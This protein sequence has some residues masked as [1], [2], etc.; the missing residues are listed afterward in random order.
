MSISTNI[1]TIGTTTCLDY[2]TII[3][4]YNGSVIENPD[5]SVSVFLPTDSGF[6]PLILGKTCCEFI[7]PTYTFDIETQTCKWTEKVSGCSLDNIIKLVINP[8]GNDGTLFYVVDN[9]N[10]FLNIDFNYLFKIKCETL[11]DIINTN[12]GC[13]TPIEL[14]ETFD[15]SLTIDII[16]SASTLETVVEIPLFQPIGTGNLYNYLSGIT[17]SGF[18]VC[19]DST[20]GCI[21]LTLNLTGLT[22]PNTSSCDYVMTNI[23][24]GLFNE[25]GLSGLSSANDIFISSITQNVL[26]S[27][28]L[29][30][31]TAITDTTIINSIKNQLIKL[32]IKINHACSDFCV[33]LD[34]IILDKV[35]THVD[36]TDIFL[37]QSPGF[38][39]NRVI[40]NKKSWTSNSTPINRSFDITNNL[41]GNTIRQTNYDINDERLVINTKEID[42]DINLASAIETDV[43]YY[44]L[45]NPC[46]LTGITTCDPCIITGTSLNHSNCCGDNSIDFT[47]LMTQ[48]LS[49]VTT[50]EDFEYFLT[51]ELIDAKNRQTISGYPTL[52]ALYDRYINSGLY[53]SAISSKFDYLTMD[54]FASLIGNYW[55]DIVEQVVPAT[56]IWGSVKIY[57]NT[58]FDQQKFKYKA[59]SSLFCGNPF[60]GQTLPSPINGTSGTC[61]SVNVITTPINQQ[62]GNNINIKNSITTVCDTLCLAQMNSGSEFLGTISIVGPSTINC[63][64]TSVINECSLGATVNAIYPNASV[65]LVGATLP[66]TYLWSNSGTG[67]TTTFSVSG[68]YNVQ[69]TDAACCSINIEFNI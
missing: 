45:D 41:G 58:I 6:S 34:E 63:D 52:R 61:T 36:R 15:V 24:E 8:K 17:N 66:V 57:S 62:V 3:I 39:L 44:I 23:I 64:N 10:C 2:N 13:S 19:G 56:T 46:L 1:N 7:K 29:N 47:S 69:I 49:G 37:T 31:T 60:S 32:S 38:E 42:L 48:P 12:K 27:N 30:F 59:Y 50:I 35:C 55:V 11:S 54:Q 9:D 43:W 25:S 51:S 33:L 14:F 26:A 67:A 4:D 16:T 18:Y 21:P 53:C 5:G 68:K 40:D 20:D 65:D 28:W 22:I